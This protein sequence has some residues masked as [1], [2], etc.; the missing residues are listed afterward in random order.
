MYGHMFTVMLAELVHTHIFL[1]FTQHTR[2]CMLKYTIMCIRYDVPVNILCI[3]P[4]WF[5]YIFI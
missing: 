2:V 3:Y 1:L 5:N 4:W